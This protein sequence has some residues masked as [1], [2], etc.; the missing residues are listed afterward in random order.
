MSQ[1]LSQLLL[2]LNRS[3]CIYSGSGQ[4]LRGSNWFVL[5]WNLCWQVLRKKYKRMHILQGCY[6]PTC[7]QYTESRDQLLQCQVI[8]FFS[9]HILWSHKLEDTI[10]L[11]PFLLRPWIDGTSKLCHTNLIKIGISNVQILCLFALLH[12]LIDCLFKIKKLSF[13]LSNFVSRLYSMP[14]NSFCWCAL[15]I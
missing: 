10:D 12:V 5:K 3:T 1:N 9:A 8:Y 7:I 11:W 14:N 4:N 6:W 2:K 15:G 13:T